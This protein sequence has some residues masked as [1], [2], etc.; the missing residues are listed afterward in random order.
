MLRIMEQIILQ[1]FLWIV[2]ILMANLQDFQVEFHLNIEDVKIM[3]NEIETLRF[4]NETLNEE[5]KI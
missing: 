5:I 1:L 2:N 3:E 4:Q